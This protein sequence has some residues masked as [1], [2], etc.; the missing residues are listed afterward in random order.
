MK[1]AYYFPDSIPE[2]L[3]WLYNFF[4]QIAVEGPGLG[5]SPLQIT[6]I[7]AYIT[8]MINGILAADQAMQVAQQKVSDRDSCLLTNLETLRQD[9]Q[10]IKDKTAYTEAIGKSLKIIGSEIKIDLDTVKTI[11]TLKKTQDGIDIKFG[12]QHCE[13]GKIYC[14][15]AKETEFSFLA[16]VTHPH[17]IDTRPNAD[18]MPSEVRKYKV[19]LVYKDKEVGLDSDIAEITH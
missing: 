6:A 13:G 3:E 14:M 5:F 4:A 1:H 12:M 7:Q 18:E 17:Y 16:Q 15:R 9:I 11:V 10:S 19:V 8:L 2:R